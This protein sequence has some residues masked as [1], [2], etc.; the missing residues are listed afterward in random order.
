MWFHKL[1]VM[2]QP[3]NPYKQLWQ[4]GRHALG[5]TIEFQFLRIQ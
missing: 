5:L 4:S 2:V 3:L 1:Q